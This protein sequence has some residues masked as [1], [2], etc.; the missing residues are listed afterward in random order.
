VT[1]QRLD[2]FVT[3]SCGLSVTARAG[4]HEGEIGRVIDAMHGTVD[5]WRAT[6]TR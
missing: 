1:D 6:Q 3:F 2:L 4:A 5:T